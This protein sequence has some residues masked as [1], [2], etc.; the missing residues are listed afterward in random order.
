MAA[1]LRF[2]ARKVSRGALQ[3]A[4]AFVSPSPAVKEEQRRLLPEHQT[5]ASLTQNLSRMW[6]C[7]VSQRALGRNLSPGIVAIM[8]T[9]DL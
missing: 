9:Q 2:A 4:T 5:I 1:A 6:I 7:L 8:L 3:Q